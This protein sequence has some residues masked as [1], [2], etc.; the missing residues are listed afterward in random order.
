MSRHKS[1]LIALI[2]TA[3]LITLI[4]LTGAGLPSTT[5]NHAAIHTALNQESTPT[6]PTET[7]PPT[8]TLARR[9][10]NEGDGIK[11]V[12]TVY[13]PGRGP[14]LPGE[15]VFSGRRLDVYVGSSTFSAEEVADLGVKAEWAVSYIQKRFDAQLTERVSVGVYH[16]SQAPGR[17]TRGIAYTY[18]NTN[19]RIYYQAGE[20]KHNALVILVHELSH[21]L[22]AAAYGKEEQARVDLVLLEGLACWISGE[23]WLSLSE[24]P[25][26]QARASELYRSGIRGNLAALGKTT[27]ID[28]A[29][30]MWAGFVDYLART[31]GWEKFNLLYT[32]GN[33]RAPGSANYEGIYGKTFEELYTDWYSTLE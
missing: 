29:Y 17:G 13:L 7:P 25:S 28:N 31:Y 10:F 5:A 8:A 19:V 20:D 2:I 3:T 32:T 18:G 27:S 16:T 14:T 30:D 11:F 23:Y 9:D 12:P 6:L 26:F 24:S 21:A 33:G 15:M 1:A 22:Q 4:G